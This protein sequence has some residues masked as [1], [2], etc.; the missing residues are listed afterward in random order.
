MCFEQLIYTHGTKLKNYPKQ[1]KFTSYFFLQILSFSPQGPPL[2]IRQAFENIYSKLILKQ[3]FSYKNLT[4]SILQFIK[5]LN[6]FILLFSNHSMSESFKV[7]FRPVFFN[8]VY[9]RFNR[10]LSKKYVS[11][12]P[13]QLSRNLGDGLSRHQIFCSLLKLPSGFQC[14]LD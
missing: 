11:S 8:L 1:S 9:I 3:Y 4:Y 12:Q 14:T 5:F 2:K 13:S 6:I 7:V 10:K